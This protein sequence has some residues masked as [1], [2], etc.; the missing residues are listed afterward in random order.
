MCTAES[1]VFMFPAPTRATPIPI[2]LPCVCGSLRWGTDAE[3]R[4]LDEIARCEA[5]LAVPWHEPTR[6]P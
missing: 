6:W 4:A 1:H 3:L 2:G 5:M